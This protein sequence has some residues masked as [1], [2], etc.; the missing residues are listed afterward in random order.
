MFD[1]DRYQTLEIE[2]DN[3]GSTL[4]RLAGGVYDLRVFVGGRTG[5]YA[6]KT[7]RL[8]RLSF[9]ELSHAYS[10]KLSHMLRGGLNIGRVASLIGRV[11]K[12]K[13]SFGM[14][15]GDSRTPSP[16]GQLSSGKLLFEKPECIERR[17]NALT[18]R[19]CFLL[20][21]PDGQG[22]QDSGLKEQIYPYFTLDKDVR[23]D[24]VVWLGEGDV[25]LP[26]ALLV[27]AEQFANNSQIRRY[28]VDTTC[29]GQLSAH[30]AWDPVLYR[31]LLPTPYVWRG[32]F[33]AVSDILTLPRSDCAVINLPLAIKDKPHL[34]VVPP[35]SDDG[36]VAH[37]AAPCSIIIPTRDRS[38]L[39]EACLAGLF[40]NTWWPHEVIVV[41][42]GSTEPRTFSL[43]ETYKAKGLK[44]IRA[45][46]PFN[47][48]VLCNIG[49]GHAQHDYLL[50]L[51]NDIVLRDTN[52]LTYI[53]DE[54]QNADAGAVG[55]R[56]LYADGRLQHG[57]VMLGVTQ[58]CGHLWR[59]LSEVGQQNE[60]RLMQN[61]L[62]SAV[63]GAALCVNRQK[64]HQAG[65][66]D[67]AHFPVTLG[68]IDL[69]L[70]L[71]A[72]GYNTVFVAQA[73]AYHLEG[74]SR[75]DDSLP[76]KLRRRQME[77][78]AFYAKWR[79]LIHNDPWLPAS[80][81]RGTEVFRFR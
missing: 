27:I 17:L 78:Q 8:K 3:E 24:G 56:L 25:L 28:L 62:R 52:W 32:H 11:L 14:R 30:I 76:A 51:N 69:C 10:R 26:D 44:V 66:F 45:D 49:A 58:M 29:A 36:A 70:K 67:E 81:S 47:F 65:M 54:A 19:P 7:A 37:T 77:L 15:V 20:V 72:L 23:H 53:M 63:T 13:N 39:L 55:M 1:K 41:D 42:N 75:G 16:D 71:N 12:N 64:F 40:E 43:L 60:P 73:V 21:L 57:G 68:D 33:S 74:E 79:H 2:A 31:R 9:L 18:D 80:V 38:D 50:F 5:C 35:E 22:A 34:D 48:S 59:G 46:V 4:L 61:S 6:F